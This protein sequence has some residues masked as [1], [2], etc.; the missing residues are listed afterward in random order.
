MKKILIAGTGPLGRSLIRLYLERGDQVCALARTPRSF[1]GLEHPALRTVIADV[2]QPATLV[3][4]CEGVD[5]V[6]SCLGITRSTR[7]ATH[8]EVDFFGNLHLLRE[9]ERAGVRKFGV[10]SPEGVDGGHGDVPLLAAKYQFEE[11]LKQSAV[12]WMIF[13]AGGFFQDLI[14]MGRAAERGLMVVFGDGEARFTPVA[15]DDVATVAA[16]EMERRVCEIISIG[17]PEEMSWNEVCR[18]CFAQ[19]G[20]KERVLKISPRFCELILPLVRPFSARS[21]AMG[22]LLL[23]MCTR[24]VISDR[25]GKQRFAEALRGAAGRPSP[26]RR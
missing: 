25:R 16:D 9:A 19:S 26:G 5:Y 8:R 17:G 6:F 15:V 10:I 18:T 4:V 21:Y 23:F 11:A 24:D 2:T 22:R 1:Q 7:R 12:P 14:A 20:R 3:G 13:R